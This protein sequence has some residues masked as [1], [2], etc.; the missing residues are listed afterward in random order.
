MCRKHRRTDGRFMHAARDG[1][2]PAEV[3]KRVAEREQREAVDNR[4][5][6]QKWLNDPSPGRSALAAKR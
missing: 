1:V 3:A 6:A 5:D 2:N 4:T